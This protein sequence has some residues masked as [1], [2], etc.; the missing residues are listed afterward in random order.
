MS[1]V[2]VTISTN[3]AYWSMAKRTIFSIRKYIPTA[4]I[5]LFTDCPSN[6]GADKQVKIP[7]LQWPEATLKRY[8][9]IL[10][11]KKWLLNF[12]HVFWIDSDMEI[13]S[14][15]KPRELEYELVGT[16][17]YSFKG[18]P[19]TPEE[20]KKSSAYVSKEKIRTY[21]TGSFQGGETKRFLSLCKSCNQT[22]K[23]DEKI[24]YVARWHDESHLNRYFYTHPP[25]KTLINW[26]KKMVIISKGHEDRPSCC[27]KTLIAIITCDKPE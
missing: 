17:H 2:F 20:S 15:I 9:L 21:F 14:P 25:E 11:E 22:I 4:K 26:N 13:I 19:G 6:L 3:P 16:E 7:S 23:L 12:S 5:L 27:G 10:S 8:E 1:L 18:S 24:G